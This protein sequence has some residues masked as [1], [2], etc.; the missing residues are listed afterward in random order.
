MH[1]T[2]GAFDAKTHF[3]KLLEKVQA[4][5]HILITKHG[6]PIAKIIPFNNTHTAYK[7]DEA[8]QAIKA[9][10]KRAKLSLKGLDW[11]ALRDEGRR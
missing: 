11:K 4:G 8:I 5:E 9:F 10:S 2:F 1:N 7:T 6:H 3:S